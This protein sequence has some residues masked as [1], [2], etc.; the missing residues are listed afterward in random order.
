MSR[1]KKK[2]DIGMAKQYS[3]F[4][5][6]EEVEARKEAG[7]MPGSLNLQQKVK[8]TLTVALKS[9]PYKRWEVAG[10]MSDYIGVEITESML[11]AWTAESKELH[12]FPLEYLP[13]FCWATGNYSLAD[14]V[15][16]ASGCHLIK[17][18]EVVLLEMARLD[19]RERDIQEQKR[20]MR[21]YLDKMKRDVAI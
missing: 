10:R 16:R 5:M 1:I 2:I 17:S 4:D 15:V 6:L 3:I 18:E 13:A 20:Q 9:A 12:R 19:E 14:V 8:E 11:N 7:P 21:N